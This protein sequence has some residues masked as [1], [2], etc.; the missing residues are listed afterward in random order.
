MTGKWIKLWSISMLALFASAC[1]TE[2]EELDG[3]M[4]STS[5]TF[6]M[7][8]VLEPILSNTQVY[9]FDGEGA[10]LNHF[11][12]KVRDIRYETDRLTMSVASGKWN[13]TLVSA[14]TEIN[15]RLIWPVRGAQ[16]TSLKMWETTPT[17]GG[18]P[19]VP[20]LRTAFL[21]GQ[22]VV[23]N[24]AN[25]AADVASL[26]RNV[27][28]VK[29][30]IVNAG[31]LDVNGIHSFELNNVP[32]T[33]NWCG[34]L[35]PTKENPTVSAA[36]MRGNFTIH[37]NPTQ[38]NHQL[39][40]T[41]Q[42]IIP[43]HKGADYMDAQPTDTTTHQL[44]LS[45]NMACEGGG[46]YEK[47]EVVIP[48]VPRANGVLL[49]RL[50]LGVKLEVM[51]E[52]LDWV[53]KSVDGDVPVRKLSV[54]NSELYCYKNGSAA[55]LYFNSNQPDVQVESRT[56]L[57]DALAININD[58]FQDPTGAANYAYN[59]DSATGQG[60]GY[61]VFRPLATTYLGRYKIYLNAGGLRREIWVTVGM[62]VV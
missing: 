18:L 38:V 30:V 52:L 57:A 27:A 51:T 25:V 12:Q 60:A 53:S 23:A 36:P 62:G 5:L 1:T 45:L 6:G 48:R 26:S 17:G 10:N 59:Y 40:D 7:T 37:N 50:K 47:K 55:Y 35:Y 8:R 9:L 56:L 14:D 2:K 39:S 41:L 61:M 13:V 29:V 58:L 46:R 34:G 44:K 21:N 16:P 31:G 28:L 42:F 54:S 22:E 11:N 32:T 24:Q 49:V 20:E 43:A 3:S 15:S 4:G 33:L 19:S